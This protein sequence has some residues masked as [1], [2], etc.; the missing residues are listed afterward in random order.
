MELT[1]SEHPA[2]IRTHKKML[3]PSRPDTIEEEI[4]YT[5][6]AWQ[7]QVSEKFTEGMDGRL[8]G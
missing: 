8:Q 4:E 2:V 1:G 5:S 7:K 6:M 3:D